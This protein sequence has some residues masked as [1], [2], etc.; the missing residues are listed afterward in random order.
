[1]GFVI[2]GKGVIAIYLL[3]GEV[4]AIAVYWGEYMFLFGGGEVNW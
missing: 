2:V 1:M 4:T 3:W